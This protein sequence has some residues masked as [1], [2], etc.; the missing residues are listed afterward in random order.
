MTSRSTRNEAFALRNEISDDPGWA[1][2]R[3]A[4]VDRVYRGGNIT[5]HQPPQAMRNKHPPAS[6]HLSQPASPPHFPT[7][8]SSVESFWG[9]AVIRI[10]ER[11]AAPTV[12]A[13]NGGGEDAAM[14]RDTRSA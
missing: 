2:N 11:L 5:G 13:A 1:L 4:E 6:T 12:E 7:L 14:P 9:R 10:A 3:A 8:T